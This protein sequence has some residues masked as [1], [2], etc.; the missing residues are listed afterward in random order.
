MSKK[1]PTRQTTNIA[2][3]ID[4]H[5]S[6]VEYIQK[7]DGKVGKFADKAIQEKINKENEK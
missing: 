5:K 6:L 7:I 4:T 3:S 2:I 1:K